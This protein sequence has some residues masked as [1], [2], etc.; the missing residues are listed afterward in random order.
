[1]NFSEVP[2]RIEQL[3]LQIKQLEERLERYQKGGTD[4]DLF[5]PPELR[6]KFVVK[7]GTLYK[8]FDRS[9]NPENIERI[10]NRL[11]PTFVTDRP[12]NRFKM[13]SV[14]EVAK[15]AKQLWEEDKA[16]NPLQKRQS[17]PSEA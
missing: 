10:M 13:Y 5:I 14:E 3:Q 8:A 6:G 9:R 17:V 15:V 16:N 7:T 11:N 12:D 1:M 4:L 2:E